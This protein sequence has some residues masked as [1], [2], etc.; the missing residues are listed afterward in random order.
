MNGRVVNLAVQNGQQ[1]E[2]GQPLIVLEAMKME[3]ALLAPFAGA[4]QTLHV[5]LG[6][7]VEPGR[8]LA[9]LAKT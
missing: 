4:V 9:E 3:H 6:D 1:V 7:Q 5:M 8:V 2:A